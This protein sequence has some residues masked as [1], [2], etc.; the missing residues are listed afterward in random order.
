LF[1]LKIA[2]SG[3]GALAKTRW[4]HFNCSDKSA[5]RLDGV[6]GL[7][8]DRYPNLKH[9]RST[10]K[11]TT[12]KFFR[13]L[14]GEHREQPRRQPQVGRPPDRLRHAAL[15]LEATMGGMEWSRSAP[16]GAV[17]RH[18]AETKGPSPERHDSSGVVL[19]DHLR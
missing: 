9:T 8:E 4:V 16:R 11:I 2:S 14:V 15:D 6:K 13:R 12:H 18:L 7:R 1:W 5:E 17:G 19:P 10:E 3:R